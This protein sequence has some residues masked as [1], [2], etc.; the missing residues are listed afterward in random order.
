[1][2]DAS[3][4][5]HPAC[6]RRTVLLADPRPD[7]LRPVG[8]ALAREF[9]VELVHDGGAAFEAVACGRCFVA[10]VAMALPALSGLEVLRAADDVRLK[11]VETYGIANGTQAVPCPP[12]VLLRRI[13]QL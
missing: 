12:G 9:A 3:L 10:V 8:E 2:A 6:D 13:W 1:M 11:V 4:A 7:R 5:G